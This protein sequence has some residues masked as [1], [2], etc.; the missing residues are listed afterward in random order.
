PAEPV[1]RRQRRGLQHPRR[2]R[3]HRIGATGG[4]DEWS[5][6]TILVRQ[7]GYGATCCWWLMLDCRVAGLL[8]GWVALFLGCSVAWFLGLSWVVRWLKSFF[9]GWRASRFRAAR[10]PC[11]S[12]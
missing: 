12:A 8:S 6:G 3:R 10:S 1:P 11:R 2:G 4:I 7:R 9:Q 5:D